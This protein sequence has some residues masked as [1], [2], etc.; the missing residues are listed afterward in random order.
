M[1]A[2][3]AAVACAALI[4]AAA[5]ASGSPFGAWDGS[6]GS[7]ATH[8]V[9]K[10]HRLLLPLAKSAAA[11]TYAQCADPPAYEKPSAQTLADLTIAAEAVA[12]RFEASLNASA[13]FT[14]A[15]L[16]VVYGD[17]VLT[18]R[19]MGSTRNDV[20]GKAVDGGTQF[21]IGSVSKVFASLLW[22]R[23]AEDGTV[24][25]LDE[26]VSAIADYHP[27]RADPN[28]TAARGG[29][30]RDL[31][32][33]MA[34]LPRYSPCDFGNCSISRAEGL[35]RINKWRLLYPPGERVSYSNA[36]FSLLGRTL[37]QAANSTWDAEASAM[38][39]QAGMNRTTPELPLPG[40][41][42]YAAAYASPTASAPIGTPPLGYEAPAG[43][44]WSTGDDMARLMSLLLRLEGKRA[45]GVTGGG[46]LDGSTLR[47]WLTQRTSLD[48]PN[49]AEN[50]VFFGGWGSPWEYYSVSL[51]STLL[52]T[53]FGL[54]SKDG[55]VPGYH[56][57]L[58]LD[59]A[60]RVGVFSS[61]TE[62][63]SGAGGFYSD[64]VIFAALGFIP[65]VVNVL[66]DS[67]I[68]RAG[69][70]VPPPAGVP[71]ILG[72][73]T[74]KGAG[75]ALSL[76][77]AGGGVPVV[78][79]GGAPFGITNGTTLSWLGSGLFQMEPPVGDSCLDIENGDYWIFQFDAAFATF[80]IQG[81]GT[82]R[83]F[84][85]M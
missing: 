66:Q 35:G 12:A 74:F 43:G 64:A 5:A 56:T 39:R 62:S 68:P 50:S 3:T 75:V 25:S 65:T 69:A 16:A 72:D 34:G 48:F 55:S 17:D 61:M 38:F 42:N 80:T 9:E 36:G 49:V 84:Y 47:R 2:T 53:R 60:S 51:N 81:F 46:L 28:S 32:S 20:A 79:D 26:E 31:A 73:W 78:V 1:T 40:D 11:P 27:A 57:Q 37:A 52:Y 30:L 45:D 10:R 29:T 82:T 71:S 59:P 44:V 77:D 13:A 4:L 7:A 67:G 76:G 83:A 22:Q 33:H 14:G 15:V 6:S 63:G 18:V 85:K 19:G 21:R 58:V 24:S 41:S 23:G 8:R 54:P 70:P